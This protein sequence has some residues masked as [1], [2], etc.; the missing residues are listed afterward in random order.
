MVDFTG[1]SG[2]N[3]KASRRCYLVT[4]GQGNKETFDKAPW[5]V[6][7]QLW[8]CCLEQHENYGEYYHK[9]VSL[10]GTNC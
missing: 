8:L 2:V 5:N 1:D 3:V 6:T 10:R 7:V 9:V 4:Y